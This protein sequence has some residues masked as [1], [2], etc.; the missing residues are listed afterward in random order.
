MCSGL[1]LLPGGKYTQVRLNVMSANIYFDNA[2]SSATPCAAS[3]AAP[4]GT[5]A[6]VD[7]PSA[8]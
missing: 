5:S 7:I 4:K 2:S 1:R 3:I 8:K 6:T